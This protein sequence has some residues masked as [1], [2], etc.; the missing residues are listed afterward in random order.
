MASVASVFITSSLVSSALTSM[1]RSRAGRCLPSPTCANGKLPKPAA[2]ACRRPARTAAALLLRR[3]LGLLH[4][5]H[6]RLQVGQRPGRLGLGRELGQQRE[7][8]GPEAEDVDRRV[9]PAGHA[10]GH[11]AE[12]EEEQHDG[13]AAGPASQ[14]EQAEDRH[15]AAAH[16]HQR[17]Q[18]RRRAVEEQ[19]DDGD[20]RADEEQREAPLHLL[21]HQAH[22]VGREL[23]EVEGHLGRD[24]SH[25][26]VR[27]CS[28]GL[29]QRVTAAGCGG[30][31]AASSA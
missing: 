26:R 24:L 12:P 21:L 8:E 25:G 15:R 23:A 31:L 18:V 17:G 20:H 3:L 5:L 10:A 19:A 22:R 14:A 13:E 2:A 11:R 6:R 4:R 16:H 27:G 9:G 7:P 1:T 29:Q 30:L 28:S